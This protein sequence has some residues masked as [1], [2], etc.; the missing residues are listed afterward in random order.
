MGL[1]FP[2]GSLVHFAAYTGAVN[3]GLMYGAGPASGSAWG[4]GRRCHARRNRCAATYLEFTQDR[5]QLA[6]E[7]VV[8][9]W[10]AVSSPC[11]FGRS[12][13]A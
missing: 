2:R 1:N 9:G 5:N 10:P 11:S 13:G 3:F 4:R 8:D 7:C 6:A 12:S